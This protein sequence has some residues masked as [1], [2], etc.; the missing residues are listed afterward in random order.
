[1]KKSTF[2]L[3][4]LGT[5]FVSVPHANAEVAS[6][7]VNIVSVFAE[8]TKD[9]QFVCT[10]VINNQ[11]DDAS[12]D[13]KVIVLLPL[14]VTITRMSVVQ[15]PGT[16]QTSQPSGLFHGYAICD[17]GNLPQGPTVRRTVKIE[18]TKSTAAP[19]YPQ[20]CSAFIYSRVGDIQKNNNYATATV[21]Y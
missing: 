3:V 11:N 2:I 10:A 13:T 9:N 1:M 15:G 16:C 8:I 18:T 6:A 20:T 17:L 12:Q 21:P 7:D 19:N 4:F 5:A 14:Q